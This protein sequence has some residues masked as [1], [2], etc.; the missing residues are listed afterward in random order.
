MNEDTKLS[1]LAENMRF[2]ADMRFKQLTV[3]MA[4]MTAVAAGVSQSNQYRWWIA[5]GGLWITGVIWVM[6]IRSTINFIENYEKA[7]ELWPRAD[8]KLFPWLTASHAVLLLY[9]G[10][11]A[12]WLCCIKKWGAACGVSFYI[13]L[14]VGVALLLFSMANERDS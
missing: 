4:A 14:I 10:F 7:K 12:F 8:S 5:L 9:A 11:Y 3:F 13:G 1:Q 6:E 2:F